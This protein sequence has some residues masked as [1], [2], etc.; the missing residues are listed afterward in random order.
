MVTTGVETKSTYKCEECPD[1]P[2]TTETE[3]NNQVSCFIAQDVKYIHTALRKVS[4]GKILIRNVS[5]NRTFYCIKHGERMQLGFP[6]L[7][8]LFPFNTGRACTASKGLGVPVFSQ[9][10]TGGWST[11]LTHSSVCIRPDIKS[12]K[13]HNPPPPLFNPGETLYNA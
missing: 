10:G 8:T 11:V 3:T 9:R 12:F 6:F 5:K 4:D 7:V 1:E 13:V 2:V